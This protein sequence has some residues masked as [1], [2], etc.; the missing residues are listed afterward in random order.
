MHNPAKK[1]LRTWLMRLLLLPLFGLAGA[2]GGG[3]GS[4]GTV[5]GGG[6]GNGAGTVTPTATASMVFS[7]VD[8]NDQPSTFVTSAAPLTAKV[9]IKDA[10]GKPV[11]NALVTFAT[12]NALAILSPSSGNTLTDANGLAFVTVRPASLAVSGAGKL[13]ASVTIA[14]NTV[15][16]ESNYMIGATAL[17]LS[18]VTLAIGIRAA[19]IT[20]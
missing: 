15:V 14:G 20:M 7:F 3:G 6:N 9:V 17:T 18:A 8:V 11:A 1:T 12:D 10:A 13:T 4:P 16:G 2:C 19:P 5:G